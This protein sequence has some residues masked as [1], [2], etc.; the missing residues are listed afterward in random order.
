MIKL[1]ISSTNNNSNKTT[2]ILI[3]P[4]DSQSLIAVFLFIIVNK[5]FADLLPSVAGMLLFFQ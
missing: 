3:F 2:E 4:F 5:I 1:T